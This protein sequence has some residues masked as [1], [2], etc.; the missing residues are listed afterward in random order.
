MTSPS[1]GQ[2]IPHCMVY[3][4]WMHHVWPIKVSDTHS[5]GFTLSAFEPQRH[6]GL[7]LAEVTYK[8][9]EKTFAVQEVKQEPCVESQEKLSNSS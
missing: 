1:D 6:A 2:G 8:L 9:M 5:K 4:R 7:P 3:E